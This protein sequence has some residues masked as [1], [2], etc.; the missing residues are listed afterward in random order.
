MIGLQAVVGLTAQVIEEPL[1]DFL[2]AKRD[3][4]IDEGREYLLILVPQ[5]SGMLALIRAG[6]PFA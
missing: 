1:D 5:P 6:L 2:V 3:L 4:L